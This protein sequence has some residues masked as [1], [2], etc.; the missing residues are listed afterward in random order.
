MPAFNITGVARVEL[1]GTDRDKL[2]AQARAIMGG[3]IR[4]QRDAGFTNTPGFAIICQ[5]HRRLGEVR[6]I[7]TGVI[8]VFW[9]AQE[10]IHG[11]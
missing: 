8:A 5:G 3:I 10:R 6:V 4:G 9:D 7:P 1:F 2:A 11:D